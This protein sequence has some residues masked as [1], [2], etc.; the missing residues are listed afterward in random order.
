MVIGKRTKEGRNL[1]PFPG[2]AQ[3]AEATDSNP[4]K[5]EFES[6]SRDVVTNSK[7]QR[8][9]RKI[10]RDEWIASKGGVCAFCGSSNE[11]QVDHIDPSTKKYNPYEL[12]H[13]GEEFRNAELSKCQVLCYPCHKEKTKAE[14]AKKFPKKEKSIKREPVSHGTYGFYV[15]HKCRC[16]ECKVAASSYWRELRIKKGR[17]VNGVREFTKV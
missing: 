14:I 10:R 13:R 8:E 11:L 9:L 6:Q 5:S 16:A 17:L 12:W 2:F 4:V 1:L 3:L 7:R 15:Y